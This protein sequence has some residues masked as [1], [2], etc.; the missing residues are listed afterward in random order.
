MDEKNE[1][2]FCLT[3]GKPLDDAL[4]DMFLDSTGTAL[5]CFWDNGF[6]GGLPRG[7]VGTHR[8]FSDISGAWINGMG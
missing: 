6:A 1:K 2:L 7:G 5:G 8:S 3:L 4:D